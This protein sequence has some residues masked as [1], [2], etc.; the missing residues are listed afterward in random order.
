MVVEL[1]VENRT[2]GEKTAMID[3]IIP[4]YMVEKYLDSCIQS[5]LEQSYTDYHIILVDDGSQDHSGAICDRYA[6]KDSRITVIHKQNGGLSSARNAGLDA[7]N[8]E[9]VLFLDSDD[10]LT[11]NALQIL[12]DAI[13]KSKADAVFAA[14]NEV[15]E[16]GKVIATSVVEEALLQDD[17]R[18]NIVYDNTPLIMACGKLFKR[19]LFGDAVRFPLGKLHEDVFIYHHL[20]YNAE[21][22]Y[23]IAEPVFNY[24]QR[25]QSI[26]GKPFALKN[27]DAVDGLLERIEFFEEKGLSQC[28]Q[29]TI[30]YLFKYLLYII[31]R[32]DFRND[33][34]KTRFES[35]YEKWK[36]L[37]HENK[38]KLFHALCK[39]YG[40]GLLKKPFM[41]YRLMQT[42]LKARRVVRARKV[43]WKLA[44]ADLHKSPNYILISTP[45]HGNLG[46]QAIVYAQR[47]ILSE[48][49]IQN[50]VEIESVEYL[51]R[52]NLIARL[53]RK[54]DVIIIDGGGNLGSLW[55]TEA[56]RINDIVS[57]FQ[58][59]K[60]IIFPET[61][62]FADDAAGR[63][64][65]I[66]TQ[67]AFANHKDLHVFLRDKPSYAIMK[68]MLPEGNIALCPDIVLSLKGKVNSDAQERSGALILLRKDREKTLSDETQENITKTL[69][70]LEI[71][72]EFSDTVLDHYVTQNTR[73]QELTELF[74]KI[75]SKQIVIT[76]RLH[77]MIFS[78]ITNTPCIAFNNSN[79]KVEHQYDW[80]GKDAGIV[81]LDQ[82]D[83]L[84]PAIEKALTEKAKDS[85]FDEQM[86][87]VLKRTISNE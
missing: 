44:K 38:D 6:A 21:S 70:T 43:L 25:D 29:Q 11:Q 55:P 48:C 5:V 39:M 84:A 52:K 61:A 19:E 7:S 62:F 42:A 16:S 57:R 32:I 22:I 28:E 54:K 82:Q 15:D 35:Y 67:K 51:T 53:I 56:D 40:C 8:G 66:L 87:S 34:I 23:C 27:F 14:Y 72:Y 63:T 85:T 50:I 68:K 81:L 10:T 49:G 18:F 9:Y 36:E 69:E 26:M 60:V 17:R 86:Y 41:S 24:M 77:G 80:I 59:N 79:R 76:D 31:H 65:Y 1:E 45:V 75:A 37:S 20:M 73:A 46:D 2:K 74:N 3:I 78:Y 12:Y 83:A 30:G 71:P 4:V 33:E 13:T 47:K 58:Q 64:E